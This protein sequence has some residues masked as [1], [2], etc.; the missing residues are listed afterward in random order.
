MFFKYKRVQNPVK[1]NLVYN[2][3]RNYFRTT[4]FPLAND[5]DVK[6]LSGTDE[7]IDEWLT[8]NFLLD[9]LK[10]IRQTV[11]LVRLG[12]SSTQIAFIS[13]SKIF[14]IL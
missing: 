6:T 14:R 9:N 1:A 3:I 4:K 12:G 2:L 13:K 7:S 5:D 10:S 8:V 11:G